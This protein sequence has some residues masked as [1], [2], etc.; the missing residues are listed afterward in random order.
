MFGG[1]DIESVFAEAEQIV[2]AVSGTVRIPAAFVASDV[3]TG[4]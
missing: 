4:A 1:Y 3:G 2:R